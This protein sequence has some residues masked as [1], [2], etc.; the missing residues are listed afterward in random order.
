M[1]H[2]L[3]ISTLSNGTRIL[4]VNVPGSMTYYFSAVPNAGF[5]Y[6]ENK[7]FELPH[8]LEHLAFEGSKNYPQPGQLGYELEKIGG[9][10]N[11]YTNS[12][13]IR[14][15]LLGSIKTYKRITELA[16]EKYTQ[17]LYD[18]SSID[19]QKEVVERELTRRIDNDSILVRSLTYSRLFPDIVVY[20][21]DRI[22]SL[23]NISRSDI[24]KFFKATHT[25]ANTC[26]VV[27]G[28]LPAI[29]RNNILRTI[30][31]SISVLQRGKR[32]NKVPKINTNE[33]G[34]VKSL[35]GTD[36]NQ[37]H[38]NFAFIK[39]EY[40]DDTKYQAA[41]SVAAAIYNRGEASRLFRKARSAG[42]T[43]DI[44]SGI[45]NDKDYSELYISDKTDPHL[46]VK[47]F[48][49]CMD[50]L[51]D[52]KSGNISD[53]EL[54]RAK[55]YKAG[56]F[57]TDFETARDIADWYG[58]MF[59]EQEKLDSPSE[60]AKAIRQVTKEDVVGVLNKFIKK[61][62][63][64]LSLVGPSAKKYEAKFKDVIKSKLNN[65]IASTIRAGI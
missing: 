18:K 43:Y 14:Y 44:N 60:Y 21:K 64:I 27:A 48:E 22:A 59:I 47:L 15:F 17:P 2:S 65:K 38:I 25:Q 34:K 5:N 51:I 28:S 1:R 24:L 41:C 37:M 62:N 3:H 56:A 33:L 58:P 11:A 35:V 40:E 49:L 29:R 61:D 26:F 32:L 63:W 50:E 16:L 46:A 55:G 31:K 19:E 30:E 45:S 9:W 7:L 53:E 20:P 8:L 54:I 12:F 39:P 6:A 23:K 4:F 42:L 57:D 10:S 36:K 13:I 52:M